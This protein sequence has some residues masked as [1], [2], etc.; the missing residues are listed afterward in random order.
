MEKIQE[1][2]TILEFSQMEFKNR[3]NL[4]DGQVLDMI[5]EVVNRKDV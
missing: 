2:K 1:I 5:W 4:T 3:E